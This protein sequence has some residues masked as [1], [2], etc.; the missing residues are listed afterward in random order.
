MAFDGPAM[1]VN[2]FLISG[3][4]SVIRISFGDQHQVE[5]RP[6][7]RAAVAMM[8]YDAEQL[9]EILGRYL[10]DQRAPAAQAAGAP[11]DAG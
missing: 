5:T 7:F 9:V 1:F 4:G 2:R 8:N 10:A 11:A 3:H 6:Q